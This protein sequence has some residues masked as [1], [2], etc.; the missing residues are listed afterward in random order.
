MAILNSQLCWWFLVHTGTVLANGYYRYKPTYLKPLPIP[1]VP[2]KTD[3]LI[4][5]IVKKRIENSTAQNNILEKEIDQIVYDLYELSED[6]IRIIES[7]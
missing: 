4:Q 7:L 6:D 3:L 2:K 1:Y 5:E